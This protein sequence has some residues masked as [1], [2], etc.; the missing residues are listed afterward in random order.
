MSNLNASLGL[1]SSSDDDDESQTNQSEGKEN[2]SNDNNNK[3]ADD[4]ASEELD[5]ASSLQRF[6]EDDIKV[7]PV[8]RMAYALMLAYQNIPICQSLKL[9][10]KVQVYQRNGYPRNEAP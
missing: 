1:L 2:P 3:G 7:T 5:T 9:E 6:I 10:S 8:K 4:L